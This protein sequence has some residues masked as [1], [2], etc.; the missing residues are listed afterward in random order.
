MEDLSGYTLDELEQLSREAYAE[1]YRLA[2]RPAVNP[3]HKELIPLEQATDRYEAIREEI[4]K[5]LV[6]K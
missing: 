6:S 5:R 4:L 2:T 1:Y 3:S